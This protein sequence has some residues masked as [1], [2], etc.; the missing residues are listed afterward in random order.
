MLSAMKPSDLL[1]V[2]RRKETSSSALRDV[3]SKIDIAA[4]ERKVDELERERRGLLLEGTEAEVNKLEAKIGAENRDIERLVVM[5]DEL[6]R[7]IAEAERVEA[8][9][10]LSAEL[11]KVKR[12]RDE[13]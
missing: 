5:R 6:Q 7:R 2:F 4:A 9:E 8:G 12:E 1:S 3:L 10:V 13:V 11:A